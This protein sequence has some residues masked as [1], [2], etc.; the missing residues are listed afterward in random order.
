MSKRV[1]SF[2]VA[3]ALLLGTNASVHSQYYEMGDFIWGSDVTNDGQVA[4]FASSGPYFTYSPSAGLV[5]IGGV[6]DGGVASISSDGNFIGGDAANSANGGLIEAARYDRSTGQW[7]FLGTLGSS[8]G[9]S[10]SSHW[11]SNSAGTI[12]V[13]LGWINGGTAHATYYS[14]GTATDLG[15][16]VPGRSSRANG[17]SDDGSVVVGWQDSDVGARAAAMWVNGVQSIIDNGSGGLLAEAGAVTPD[18][19]WIIGGA[20]YDGPESWRYNVSSGQVEFLG[21]LDPFNTFFG[22]TGI[23][24]DGRT[25]VGFER[26][27]PPF[28]AFGT[29][30]IWIEG[31]GMLN[32]TDYVTGLGIAL[33]NGVVLST[34]MAIS[35]NGLHIV[36]QASNGQGFLVTIPEPASAILVLA[37]LG[38]VLVR[39]RRRIGM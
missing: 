17:V 5:N 18:G 6:N 32:L 38:G 26:G 31:Q 4:G 39:T 14:G 11:G 20:G 30:T 24:D 3:C 25:I 36:G 19:E 33:P 34:P 13:G 2:L 15:S 29:G 10:A 28:P 22:A 7:N 8:S 9:T 27:F 21:I 35:G 37:A 12:S 16:S 1:F 23:T